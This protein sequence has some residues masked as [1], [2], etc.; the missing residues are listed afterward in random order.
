MPRIEFQ[1]SGKR[2]EAAPGT[3]LADAARSA[4]ISIDIPCGGNGTCGKCLARL[5]SGRLDQIK[6]AGA[7]DPSLIL[8]CQS[9][10]E[11]E[12]VVV[13]TFEHHLPAGDRDED[14]SE[15]TAA[16]AMVMRSGRNEPIVRRTTLTVTPPRPDDGHSDFDRLKSELIKQTGKKS[17]IVPL[18]VIRELPEL[19]RADNGNVVVTW[20]DIETRVIVTLVEPAARSKTIYGIAVDVGTTTVSA[21]LI[22]LV[23]N[24][25]V[26][27]RSGYNDQI[28][29]GLDVI[30][31]INFAKRPERLN[32]LR[33]RV[34]DTINRLVECI[35]ADN[36]IPD[37]AIAAGSLAG[38]TVMT[39]LLLGIIPEHIRLDPYTPAL[40]DVP[41]LSA[42]DVGIAINPDARLFFAPSVGSYVGGDI[43]AGVLLSDM[44]SDIEGV[45]L[46]LDIGTNGELVIGGRDFLITCACSAGPA[47]EGGGIDCG[48]RAAD[49]AIDRITITADGIRTYSTI[50]GIPPRGI[51][52]SGIID[53]IAALFSNGIID[54]SGKFDRS[55]KH[56]RIRSNGR[57]AEYVVESAD[58]S[59]TGA[60]IVITEPD[61]DNVM[62][63]KA[64]IY[65]ASALLLKQ[66]GLTFDDLD[67]FYIAGGFGR[68][69]S[70]ENAITLGLLPD[71]PAEKFTYLGNA[72]LAGSA[73]ALISK[74]RRQLVKQTA[75][76][77]TYVNL[78][79]ELDYMDQY[80]AALFLPHTDRDRFPSV[81]A[82]I[83]ATKR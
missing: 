73:L 47:F 72:S 42:R 62:R 5:L 11:N 18:A 19:L 22:D 10:L 77:M 27:V 26:A 64:A 44:I 24:T 50:G 69:L 80:T 56:P 48:M 37:T 53:L 9:R 55:G 8:A 83:D 13:E 3:E 32:D 38:N 16:I 68:Y 29:C 12:D 59:S 43:T 45:R 34:L 76:R 21:M 23:T 40:Y 51:C 70:V 52:G 20:H 66:V 17:I 67:R 65:S 54:S 57:R 4:G 61:I 46:F 82:R 7:D 75:R 63:A 58:S 41:N 49:G 1:P 35:K 71:L 78:S 28:P 30:S 36:E 25:I 15:Y 6:P 74:E 33:L 60:D 31:R 14:V 79:A 2:I 81:Y 39:H